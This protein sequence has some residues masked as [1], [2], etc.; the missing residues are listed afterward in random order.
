MIMKQPSSCPRSLHDPASATT[1][2]GERRG[3]SPPVTPQSLR[4]GAILT[5]IIGVSELRPVPF[6]FPGQ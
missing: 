6:F 5:V 2:K 1:A 4:D 3:V